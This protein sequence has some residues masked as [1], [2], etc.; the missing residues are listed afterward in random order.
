MRYIVFSGAPRR[1][2][3]VETS[4]QD[5]LTWKTTTNRFE[6]DAPVSANSSGALSFAVLLSQPMLDAALS[7]LSEHVLDVSGDSIS[8]Q[9]VDEESA[10]DTSGRDTS[11]DDTA[12]T[13]ELTDPRAQ[14]SPP[15]LPRDLTLSRDETQLTPDDSQTDAGERTSFL[16]ASRDDS[17]RHE[18]SI[19]IFPSFA[20][21]PARVTTLA[22]LPARASSQGAHNVLAGVLEATGP[23][24]IN[25]KTGPV[26]LL[27][28]V[29]GDGSGPVVR[30]A[31]WRELAE[32]WTLRRGDVVHISS[33]CPRFVLRVC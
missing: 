23:E 6:L 15:L 3:L 14:A 10:E 19:A 5:H 33:K 12:I 8:V 16:T 22:A 30:L 18:E 13:W 11:A 28:L 7:R 29:L 9:P 32:E 2:E 24:T 17:Y 1:G 25:T 26:A 31:V 20:F 4:G 21:N 27:Q